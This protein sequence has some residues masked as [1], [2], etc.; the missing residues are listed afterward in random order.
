MSA[1]SDNNS[2]PYDHAALMQE[3]D[4]EV[5]RRRASGDL[6]PEFERELDMAFAQFAPP[7]ALGGDLASMLD[8]Y[9]HAAFIDVDAPVESIRP[10]GAQAKKLLRK[11]LAFNFRHMA[12]QIGSLGQA[13]LM[14]L[15]A[16]RNEQLELAR[17]IPAMAPGIDERIRS[18][19]PEQ[20]TMPI[21]E[22]VSLVGSPGGRV[23]VLGA[24]EGALVV[25][26]REGG[27]DAYGVESDSRLLTGVDDM[28]VRRQDELEHLE[29]LGP[30]V[31]DVIV[32]VMGAVSLADSLQSLALA[33]PSLVPGGRLIIVSE[34]PVTR[35]N[36]IGAVQRDLISGRPLSPETWE[37][38]M[39]GS[40]MLDVKLPFIQGAEIP[41]TSDWPAGL[42]E[43]LEPILAASSGRGVYLV[44]GTRA[45]Q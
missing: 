38:L 3:I 12:Q 2:E 29:R 17:Q 23:A 8:Q 15:R 27:V 5:R 43:S 21:S 6:T 34:D 18:I 40:G 26:L 25:A 44:Q 31:L 28:L 9:E 13:Q 19:S 41:D 37:F 10:G 14:I 11:A 1:D 24:G 4:A 35:D 30:E 32:L 16:L 33:V 45:P 7:A 39:V 36:R 42:Q 22:V 20:I